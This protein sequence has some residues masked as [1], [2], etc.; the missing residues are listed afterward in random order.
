MIAYG[1]LKSLALRRLEEAKLLR[2]NGYY[3][4]AVYLCGYVV[5]TALK[6]RICKHLKQSHYQDTGQH[7]NIFST[8]EFDRLLML[9]GLSDQV[10]V[11]HPRN[12]RLYANWSIVTE[13]KPEDRY[14]PIGTSTRDKADTVIEALEAPGSGFLTWIQRKW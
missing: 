7:K 4:G 10:N 9:A 13:W 8:H 2:D 11:A 6:A 5:E 1:D 3:D 14:S 12:R